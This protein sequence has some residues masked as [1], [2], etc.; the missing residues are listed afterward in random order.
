MAL[1]KA[2]PTASS[3]R[4]WYTHIAPPDKME[5][6]VTT[7][8]GMR[9]NQGAMPFVVRENATGEVVGCT[10]Y[11]NVDARIVAWRS[12]TR[13]MRSACSGP[14][15]IPNASSCCW[16]TLSK[17]CNVSPSNSAR[18]G[19]TTHHARRSLRLGAKQDGV[20]RN[21][22]LMPDGARGTLSCSASST[23]NGRR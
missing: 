5:E 20:L 6:Y 19:S 7:A 22:Q 15:S 2:R 23:A 3:W 18:T 16:A 13:G 10:R 11:F 9:E 12:A 14:A 21:H 8:L 17:R 4:L 1:A